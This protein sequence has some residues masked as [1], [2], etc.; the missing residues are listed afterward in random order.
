MTSEVCY[1]ELSV[2]E[3]G[4]REPPRSVELKVWVQHMHYELRR[5]TDYVIGPSIRLAQAVERDFQ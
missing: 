5:V 1:V 3:S 2:D 4:G